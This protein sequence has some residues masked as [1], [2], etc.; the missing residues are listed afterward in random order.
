MMGGMNPRQMQ[1][2]MKQLGVKTEEINATEVVIKGEKNYV[3][4]NPK[5]T[6]MEVQGQK[7]FQIAGE[8]SETENSEISEEDIELVAEKTGKTKEEAKKALQE[9]KGDIAEAIMSLA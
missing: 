5:V 1:S 8:I 2:M 4:K 9:T 7:T 3:I 6:M